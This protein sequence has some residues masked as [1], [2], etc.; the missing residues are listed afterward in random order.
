M[1]VDVM[2]TRWESVCE[3][4]HPWAMWMSS[5]ERK[6]LPSTEGGGGDE[7]RNFSACFFGLSTLRAC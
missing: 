1:H 3:R 7:V 4:H 2:D 5:P 6:A